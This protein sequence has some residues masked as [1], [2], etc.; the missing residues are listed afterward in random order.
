VTAVRAARR[1]VVVVALLGAGA[2]AACTSA[3]VRSAPRARDGASG[4][5]AQVRLADSL[6]AILARGV[7]E[8][9][10][11]GG[12]VVVGTRTAVLA[13]VAVGTLDW[14]PSP[15]VTDA[16]IW[17][18]ASLTKL[19]GLTTTVAVLVERGVLDL[20]APVQRWL[21]EWKGE[22]KATVTLRDLLAHRA[23][24]PPFREYFR[25]IVGREAVRAAV[26]AEPLEV[27][28]RTRMA[29]SDLGAILLGMVVE[30]ATGMPFDAAVATHV[31]GPLAMHDTRFTP[32]VAWRDRIAPTEVDPWRGRH[33][34]GEVHDENA[35]A[36]GGVSAH[37]GLF[38]SARDLARF[39]Q[40][41]LGAPLVDG[42]PLLQEATRRSFTAVVDA[43]FSSRALGW[44]TPTGTNSA[45]TRLSRT[46]FGHTGFTGTSLWIDPD[47]DLFVMLLTNRVNPS[48]GNSRIGPVRVAV[49]DA[50][51]GLLGAPGRE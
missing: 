12:I 27:P 1:L 4:A 31:T 45:G 29:Y 21:P 17:D 39:A 30:R 14:A 50:A 2:S 36:M 32:P 20:D 13:T 22:G 24:L 7:A 33:V 28:P 41:W 46:A 51:A 43:A 8:R 5:A 37:A 9:A 35:F 48:R 38:G 18:L 15:P 10:F 26:L 42:R 16:T 6:R 3:T 47:R 40:A 34:R 49:A 23:G 25:T 19:V 44:D 11:P